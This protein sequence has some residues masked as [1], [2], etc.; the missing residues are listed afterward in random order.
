L[1]VFG[2]IGYT[3]VPDQERSKLDNKSKRYIFIG[4]DSS[5]K[6]Y[7]LYNPNSDKI[8]IGR[9]VE[10]DEEDFWDWSTQEEEKYDLF[11]FHE[12]EEESRNKEF[13]TPSPSPTNSSTPSSSSLKGSSSEMPPHM[14]SLQE[15]YKVIENLNDDLTLYCHFADCEPIG[16]EEA[17]KDEKWRNAMDEEIKAIEK[18][19]TWELT[20]IPKEQ[21]PI[22]VK[23][24]FKA[25][26]NAKGKIERYKARLV[27]KGY[28]QRPGIDY[29]NVFALVARLETIRMVISLAAQN[30]WKIYQMDVKFA[31]L[32]GILEEE[33]YVEQPMGYVIK[34]DEKKVLKLIKTLYSLKQAPRAWNNRIDNYFQKNGFIKC[35]HEYSLYAKVCENG[36]ILFVCLYVDDL[37]F[38]DNNPSMV[39]DFKKAMTQEF[40]MTDIGLMSYYLGIK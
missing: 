28:S 22:G 39:K 19:N 8:V 11:P 15:L 26:K 34:G 32:N 18:N 36:N 13:T 5:S 1:R 21:K 20:T 35:P 14:L 27:V 4:Y 9:N 3:H 33:I 6:G 25:K 30:K 10:F 37:I 24:V 40:E 12:E 31:Y 23:L 29:G 17:V 38:T 2:S 16:F 7:K